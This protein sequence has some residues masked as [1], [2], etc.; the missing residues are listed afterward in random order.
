MTAADGAAA[1]DNSRDYT[2]YDVGMCLQFV[3]GPTWGIGSLYGSAIDAWDAAKY[4]HP[5]DRNP[6]IGAP[7]FYAGGSYGHI[8]IATGDPGRM[9]S[10]DCTTSTRVNDAAL[11][12]PETAWGDTYL[13]WT[14]DLNGVRLPVGD[15]MPLTDADVDKIAKAVWKYATTSALDGSKTTM[16]NLVRSGA[17]EAHQASNHDQTAA[18]VWALVTT[19]A[20]TAGQKVTTLNLLRWAQAAASQ[21]AEKD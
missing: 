3:R 19:S 2:S 21:A 12:W 10:T 13:G 15:D 11:S 20:L 18:A 16:G 17:A 1:L 6:P 8:V 5:G 14:E 4:R 7:C 9:R